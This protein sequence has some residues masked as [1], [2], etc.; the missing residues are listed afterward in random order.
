MDAV[1]TYTPFTDLFGGNKGTQELWMEYCI[2][3][4]GLVHRK[5]YV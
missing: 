1:E 5:L 4:R 3:I 2:R